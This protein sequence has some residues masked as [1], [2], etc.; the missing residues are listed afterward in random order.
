V[1]TIVRRAR[2]ADAAALT[3]IAHAAKRHWR[4][5][6]RWMRLW[7]DD[8][9]VTPEAVVARPLYCAVRDGAV[10]GFYGL[11]A[12]RDAPE[13]EHLWVDPRCIGTGVGRR[14][15]AHM[16]RRLRARRAVRLRIASDP[17]AVGFY[18]RMGARRIGRVPS[19]PRGR[20]L[21][22]LVVDLRRKGAP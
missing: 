13:I 17:N 15:F 9:T 3:R 12:E 2:P 10:V 7:R 11:S 22:L 4:Y 8:L 1:R 16:M 19:T 6:A 21:P 18:R 5:P 20:Y 14:L